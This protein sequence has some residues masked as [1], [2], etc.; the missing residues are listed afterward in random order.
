MKNQTLEPTK[1]PVLPPIE[2]RS[3]TAKPSPAGVKFRA[4]MVN[5]EGLDVTYLVGLRLGKADVQ[6]SRVELKSKIYKAL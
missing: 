1:T 6:G 5:S 4:K 2:R 3:P